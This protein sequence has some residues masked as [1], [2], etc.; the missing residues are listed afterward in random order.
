MKWNLFQEINVE[1]LLVQ[2]VTSYDDRFFC[3]PGLECF[4]ERLFPFAQP[5][6]AH[7]EKRYAIN[8]KK[9]W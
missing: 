1:Y 5:S 3:P 2:R 4:P 6:F 7:L 9:R 8:C